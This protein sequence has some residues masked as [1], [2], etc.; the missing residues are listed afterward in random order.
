MTEDKDVIKKTL[1]V[2]TVLNTAI[3]NFR[4][5]PPTSVSVSTTID[6]LHQ[7]FLDILAS[8]EQIF[9]AESEKALL[10]F[11]KP[12]R[13]T[14]QEKPHVISLLNILM[15]FGL[16]SISFTKG[17]EKEEV[18]CLVEL[19]SRK[20]ENIK[21]EGGLEKLLSERY[22][23][24]ILVDQKVYVAV[25]K[26]HKILAGLNITD[27]QITEFFKITHPGMDVT[28]Q[29]FQDMSRDPKALSQ[30]FASGLSKMIE[31]KETLSTVKL[32]EKLENMLS[33][34]DK[35]SGGF[36]AEDRTKISQD[37]SHSITSMSPEIAD[38]LTG[39]N[40]EHLFG[41]L[42]IQYLM[43]DL[44]DKKISQKTAG[45]EDGSGAEGGNVKGD[46]EGKEGGG[47]KAT[48][49]LVEVAQKFG[50]R[51]NDERTLM[52]EGLMSML[53]KIIEQL[54]VQKEQQ[55]L[56]DMLE[57]LVKNLKSKSSETRVSAAKG[58]SDIFTHLPADKKMDVLDRVSG[59]LL[60]WIKTETFISDAYSKICDLLKKRRFRQPRA[61]AIFPGPEIYGCVQLSRFR[62]HAIG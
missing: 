24:H 26:D 55:T 40:I 37:I 51:L 42:L 23:R 2:L 25:D 3:K 21:N 52:D 35:A 8:E 57:H 30:A 47:G 27:D 13:Q 62:I 4:L 32:S 46:S 9:F 28:S 38:Q 45:K 11:D 18:S 48:S 36:S 19:L 6:K 34:L 7:A 58:L 1:D 53:P 61:K 43:A 12:L 17:L 15:S 22:V 16:K 33:L 41:G 31:Q 59:K 14:D 56:E 39:S 49:K 54:I 44:T 60:E 50:A 10:I 20:P 29:T 5:Y